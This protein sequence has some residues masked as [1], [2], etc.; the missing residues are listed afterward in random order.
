[1][2]GELFSGDLGLLADPASVALSRGGE[3]VVDVQTV[4]GDPV[5]GPCW[6]RRQLTLADRASCCCHVDETKASEERHPAECD[7][8]E[9]RNEEGS[10]GEDPAVEDAHELVLNAAPELPERLVA[11]VRLEILAEQA[12]LEG[13]RAR[14]RD[15]QERRRDEAER[16]GEIG[17]GIVRQDEEALSAARE[18]DSDQGVVV[19]KEKVK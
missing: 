5:P 19:G 12:A 13:A 3:D 16:G 9:I 6:G 18:D 10:A 15:A 2:L 8:G 11:P 7:A 4:S 1:V 14:W 17:Q